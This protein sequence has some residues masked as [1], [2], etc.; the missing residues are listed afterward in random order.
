MTN[1]ERKTFFYIYA[2]FYFSFNATHH[3]LHYHGSGKRGS[4][5]STHKRLTAFCPGLLG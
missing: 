3:E 2:M 4:A 5:N 1:K